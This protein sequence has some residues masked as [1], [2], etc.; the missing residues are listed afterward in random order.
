MQSRTTSYEVAD[1]GLAATAHAFGFPITEINRQDPRRCR[2]V[3]DD[4]DEL[5]DLI[6]AY[7]R[8]SLTIEPQILLAALKA[9]KARL[10]AEE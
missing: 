7:W 10:Y 9:T 2:F 6:D 4:R 5:R 1:I 8:R 3:F